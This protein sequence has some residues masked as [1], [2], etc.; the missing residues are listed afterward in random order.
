M[1]GAGDASGAGD[2]ANLLKPALARGELR[3]IAATTWADYKKYVERDPA[4][5][6]RFQVVKVAE[7][8]MASAMAML[9]GLA[10]RLEEHQRVRI[11]DEAL[12]EAVRLSTRYITDGH[13]PDK[14]VALLDTACARVA[15]A[16]HALPPALEAATRLGEGLRREVEI[17]AREAEAGAYHSDRLGDLR[18]RVKS[19]EKE[20]WSLATRWEQERALVGKIDALWAEAETGRANGELKS[21]RAELAALQGEEPMV[22]VCIDADVVARIV[23]ERTGIPLGRMLRDEIEAVLHL[24]VRL[25]DIIFGQEPGPGGN[26]RAVAQLSGGPR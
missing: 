17:L 16:R 4:L 3:T 8:D 9:R 26:C 7:P 2:A 22:P 21:C 5:A 11:V 14:A 20:G 10:P 12:Q 18:R 23:A 13:L 15:V 24:E 25:S 1:I 6:R 19:A